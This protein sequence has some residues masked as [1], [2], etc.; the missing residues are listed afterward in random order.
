MKAYEQALKVD[1]E[2]AP[3][4]LAMGR[5]ALK[6]GAIDSGRKHLLDAARLDP[7]NSLPY[8]DLANSYL[9]ERNIDQAI[10]M[11][12]R[13]LERTP[14]SD[15][16]LVGLAIALLQVRGPGDADEAVLLATKACQV[17]ND[18]SPP[19]V[20]VLAEACAAAGRLPEAVAAARKAL[21]VAQQ[22]G[23]ANLVRMAASLLGE[24]D[25][26]MNARRNP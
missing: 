16:V 18:K 26:K 20:I 5:L 23:D 11:Y 2:Y 22:S 21:D 8:V 15:T 12:R 17:T 19:A 6:T 13:A 14:D 9:R 1:P 24:Y 3:T 7:D 10:V 4:L 25:Q